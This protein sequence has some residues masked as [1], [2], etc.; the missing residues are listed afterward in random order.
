[1]ETQSVIV[2]KP[3]PVSTTSTTSTYRGIGHSITRLAEPEKN[4][5]NHAQFYGKLSLISLTIF[6]YRPLFMTP[7]VCTCL[8]QE[9]LVKNVIF[10]K[11]V[12]FFSVT[13][14]K[15]DQERKDTVNILLPA[16]NDKHK[17]PSTPHT[18]H[19]PLNNHGSTE[20][21]ANKSYSIDE[22]QPNDIGPSKGPF[23]LAP[24]PAQLG[25]APLQRRQ[26]MGTFIT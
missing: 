18:P 22:T 11:F 1:M 9:Q 17:Q 26:S 7:N 10:G 24:T 3:Y 19:T 20:I 6:Q 15:S 13:N 14:I 23:M 25:R 2:S 21:S 5:N 8:E 12:I 16:T 4:E